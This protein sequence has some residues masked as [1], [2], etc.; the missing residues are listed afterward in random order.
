MT[1]INALL[2]LCWLE[3][4]S[5]YR[6]LYKR[7][8]YLIFTYQQARGKSN[9]ILL[10]SLMFQGFSMQDRYWQLTIWSGK[11]FKILCKNVITFIRLWWDVPFSGKSY[12]K[13]LNYMLICYGKKI[14]GTFC[15]SHYYNNTWRCFGAFYVVLS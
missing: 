12:S 14:I 3:L 4:L 9:W 1:C 8:T 10:G 7:H 6:A 5:Y 2:L 13:R 15:N 11:C